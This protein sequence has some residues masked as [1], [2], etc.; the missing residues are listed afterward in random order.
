MGPVVAFSPNLLWKEVILPG[1][2]VTVVHDIRPQQ[3]EICLIPEGNTLAHFQTKFPH[4]PK[5]ED[6]VVYEAAVL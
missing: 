4:Q 6:K 3:G 2:F 1:T 5:D